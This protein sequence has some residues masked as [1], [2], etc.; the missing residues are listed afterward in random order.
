MFEALAGFYEEKGYF[1]N[2]PARSRRYQ[3]L[4]EFA[5]ERVPEKGQL[6]REL[7]TYDYYLRENAKS[8]PA[9]CA[10]L[11]PYRE[12]M[13]KFYQQEEEKP[14]LLQNYREYHARQTMKMT[15]MDVFFYPVWKSGDVVLWEKRDKPMYVLFDYEKRDALTKEASAVPL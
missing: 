15:H 14:A 12:E 10:D 2:S 13:W 7:L 8:R 3:L 1:I 11:S 4:L 6:Y 9:F 5:L